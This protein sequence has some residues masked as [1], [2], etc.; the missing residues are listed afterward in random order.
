MQSPDREK[1]KAHRSLFDEKGGLVDF[2]TC[3]IFSVF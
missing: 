2:E 1:S 3:T